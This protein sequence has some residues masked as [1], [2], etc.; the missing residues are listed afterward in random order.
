MNEKKVLK[1]QKFGPASVT[2]MVLG[3]RL[4]LLGP[5]QVNGV[6]SFGR[7]VKAAVTD[8]DIANILGSSLRKWATLIGHGTWGGNGRLVALDVNDVVVVKDKVAAAAV[9]RSEDPVTLETTA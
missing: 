9:S 8:V 4:E 1:E 7:K 2:I 3:L 5:T 6:D